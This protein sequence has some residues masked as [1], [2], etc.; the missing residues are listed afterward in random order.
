MRGYLVSF[1]NV[2]TSRAELRKALRVHT[3]VGLKKRRTM[4][5]EP[6]GVIRIIESSL[7]CVSFAAGEPQIFPQFASK[8]QKQRATENLRPGSNIIP[9]TTRHRVPEAVIYRY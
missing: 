3:A 7:R 8:E 9:A 1:G 4:A 5:L 6:G 2:L